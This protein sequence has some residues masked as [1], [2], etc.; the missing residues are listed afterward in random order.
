MARSGSALALL[1]SLLPTTTPAQLPTRDGPGPREVELLLKAPQ[2]QTSVSELQETLRELLARI[3]LVLVSAQEAHEGR[4]TARVVIELADDEAHVEVRSTG[5]DAES[6]E[7]DVPRGETSSLFRETIGHVVLGLVEPLTVVRDQPAPPVPPA[8]PSPAEQPPATRELAPV[9]LAL[10]A[11]AGLLRVTSSSPAA[12]LFATLAVASERRLRP[13]GRLQIGGT[14]HS[15]LQAHGA[16]A[17]LHLF[18]VRAHALLAPWQTARWSLSTGLGGGLNVLAMKSTDTTPGV[19][20]ARDSLRVQPV[21]GALLGLHVR[22]HELIELTLNGGLDLDLQPR[23][24]QVQRGA[25]R[26]LFVETPYLIPYLTLA[27]DF[28]VARTRPYEGV[29]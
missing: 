4:V 22:L 7:R 1:L 24:W 12:W 25:E 13:A 14:P 29:R 5:R 26:L 11:G 9:V 8:Q 23:A 2:D 17:D 20:Y 15:P 16:S 27:L 28:R 19:Q 18:S 3:G 6:F 10:G 21:L